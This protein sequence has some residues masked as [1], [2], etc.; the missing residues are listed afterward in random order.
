MATDGVKII[1]GDTAHDTYW[2]IMDLY[3]SGADN[4]FIQK[5]FPLKEL[6]RY[7]DFNN[8][9][10]I[11]VCGLA[12][13]EIGLMNSK[14]LT[15]INEVIDKEACVKEWTES[16]EKEGKSRRAVLK[17]YLKKIGKTNEKLRKQKKYRKVK[18]FIFNENS[19]LTYKLP[20]DQYG[21]CCCVK[22]EQYR[23]YCTYWLVPIIYNSTIKPTIEEV[24]DLEII[25]GQ[26][27]SG[28]SRKE[29]VKLQVGIERV[30]EYLDTK[31]KF[32]WGF[33]SCGID[34]KELIFIKEKFEKIGELD[35]IS[36]LKKLRSKSGSSSF[37]GL[38]NDL[39]RIRTEAECFYSPPYPIK[40]FLNESR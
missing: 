8:E 20:N 3:D 27:S 18:N 28:F 38:I 35:F 4:D 30:W 25:G 33:N 7:D 16:S 2:G 37:E 19:V 24:I 13:W 26:I 40:I 11:T 17:R 39:K 34:H 6:D 29:M 1:D 31:M 14:H 23:G 21:L 12:Y 22:I 10:Y 5:E 32:F 36:G 15:F 9:I